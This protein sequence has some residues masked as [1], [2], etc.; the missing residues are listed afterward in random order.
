M[1]RG[2]RPGRATVEKYMKRHLLFLGIGV[3]WASL[4]VLGGGRYFLEQ[5][6]HDEEIQLI[7]QAQ[8]A[9]AAFEQ[10]TLRVISYVDVLLRGLRSTYLRTG[11]LAETQEFIDELVFDRS[12]IDSINIISPEGIIS[13]SS[14]DR[15]GKPL[16][17]T[18]R[19]YFQYHQATPDDQIFISAVEF[20]R[21]SSRYLFRISR[22][23]SHPDG[24]FAGIVL[25]AVDPQWFSGYYQE[26]NIGRQNSAALLGTQDHK[27]RARIPEPGPEAWAM[28]VESPIWSTLERED[29]G[30]YE[31][32]SSVDGIP[33]TFI[34]RKVSGLP[35]VMVVGFSEQDKEDRIVTRR[36]G[37]ITAEIGIIAVIGIL[38]ALLM[39]MVM[40]HQKLNQTYQQLNEA[41]LK[42]QELAFFDALTGLPNRAL[43]LDRFQLCL[44]TAQRRSESF[45]LLYVDLDD[46]KTINDHLGHDAGDEVL[47]TAASR[48]KNPLRSSDTVCR[49]G[50]DEFLILLPGAG[51]EREVSAIAERLVT[52]LSEPIVFNQTSCQVS[53]SVGLAIFPEHGQ[54]WGELRNAADAALYQA[55]KQ[56]KRQVS[57][58]SCASS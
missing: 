58:A 28:P 48:M 40:G 47:K 53:A 35:L 50:G 49:W 33:R 10:H 43:F 4:G 32:V 34:Y 11:S 6:R 37:L 1:D 30:L 5:M 12:T 52:A 21:I 55:K 39:I 42:I 22:R 31:W 56:G 46:F 54:N 25:A 9:A 13:A 23:I 44:L 14:R 7:R 18:D 51:N 41:Y 45:T 57:I 24:S 19:A 15:K 16:N 38:A 29:T 8:L 36:N 20:G 2:F 17:V 3:F 27:L 26:L